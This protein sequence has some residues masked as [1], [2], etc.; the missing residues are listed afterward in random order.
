[1]SAAFETWIVANPLLTLTF[2]TVLAGPLAIG[3]GGR[4]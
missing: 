3:T 1:M 2:G 4:A